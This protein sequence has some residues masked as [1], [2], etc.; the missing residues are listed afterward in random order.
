LTYEGKGEKNLST[1][2]GGQT[3]IEEEREKREVTLSRSPDKNNVGKHAFSAIKTKG[4]DHPP[5]ISWG[6]GKKKGPR[7]GVPNPP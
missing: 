6:G 1:F 3:K 2:Y 4:G 5:S 7:G